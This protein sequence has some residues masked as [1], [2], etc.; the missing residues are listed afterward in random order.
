MEQV[1]RVDGRFVRL[2]PSNKQPDIKAL[3]CP[4]VTVKSADGFY[5]E[6]PSGSPESF[7]ARD[8][9]KLWRDW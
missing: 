7:I 8:V 1:I 5:L 4:S 2:I 9:T 3:T 6:V